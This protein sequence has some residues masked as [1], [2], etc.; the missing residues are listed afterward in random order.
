[1]GTVGCSPGW[2]RPPW[3]AGVAAQMDIPI[4]PPRWGQWVARRVG[5]C[6]LGSRGL[7]CPTGP[8]SS[9]AIADLPEVTP[10]IAA[11]AS[12]H[13]NPAHAPLH[14]R[15]TCTVNADG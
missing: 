8:R 4:I 3:L 9:P 11:D 15:I 14:L 6:L 10:I 12:F 13:H 5:G 7:C 1:M 2:R